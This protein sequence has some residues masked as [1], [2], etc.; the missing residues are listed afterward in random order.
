MYLTPQIYMLTRNQSK[1]FYV[2]K[3]S[4]PKLYLLLELGRNL[5]YFFGYTIM[6]CFILFAAYLIDMFLISSQREPNLI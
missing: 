3:Q 1:H 5:C 2:T 4:N 6:S